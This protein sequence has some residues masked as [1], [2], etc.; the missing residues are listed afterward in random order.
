MQQILLYMA[1]WSHAPKFKV[2]IDELQFESTSLKKS[3]NP[4]IVTVHTSTDS[5]D[6]KVIRCNFKP[7]SVERSIDHYHFEAFKHEVIF[8]F[9]PLIYL[10]Y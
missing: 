4:T 1:Y 10:V 9:S 2:P 8:F 7:G 5:T 3:K 6:G